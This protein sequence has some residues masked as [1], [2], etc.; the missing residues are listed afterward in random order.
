MYP[1]WEWTKGK[2]KEEILSML[3]LCQIMMT[4]VTTFIFF[5]FINNA[6]SPAS[7]AAF[8]ASIVAAF[9]IIVTG[10]FSQIGV[11]SAIIAF[12]ATFFASSL[13]NIIVCGF[14]PGPIIFVLFAIFVFFLTTRGAANVFSE[15][16]RT[17][18]RIPYEVRQKFS[19]TEIIIYLAVGT[20]LIWVPMAIRVFFPSLIYG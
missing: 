13:F 10:L 5:L 19:R 2:E 7:G 17:N 18:I 15:Y 9:F 16:I 12:G 14:H 11:A 8:M 6:G 20:L 1:E 3:F 4:V